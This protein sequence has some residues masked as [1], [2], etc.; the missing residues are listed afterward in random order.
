MAGPLGGNDIS[1]TGTGGGLPRDKIQT[2][3]RTSAAVSGPAAI[4]SPSTTRAKAACRPAS[5][6][7]A[8]VTSG[9]RAARARVSAG[10]EDRQRPGRR[11]GG[12]AL[13]VLNIYPVPGRP[14]SAHGGGSADFLT[15]LESRGVLVRGVKRPVDTAG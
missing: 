6:R 8:A 12:Q 9:S 2:L 10:R 5:T 4:P 3:P 15:L 14:A 7:A 13:D 11:E 1:Q